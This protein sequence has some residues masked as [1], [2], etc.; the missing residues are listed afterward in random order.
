MQ[1]RWFSTNAVADEDDLVPL[2][3]PT[4]IL[5]P[6]FDDI[7]TP[8]NNVDHMDN[9]NNN[10]NKKRKATPTMPQVQDMEALSKFHFPIPQN[11]QQTKITSMTKLLFG[12]GKDPVCTLCGDTSFRDAKGKDKYPFK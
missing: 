4:N 7:N 12:N 6:V 2:P 11:S 3:S 5:S 8:P 1:K 9:E 10:N